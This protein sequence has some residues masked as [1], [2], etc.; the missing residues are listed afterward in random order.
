MEIFQIGD[1]VSV[2]LFNQLSDYYTK[3]GICCITHK[4][5]SFGSDV[6]TYNLIDIEN[7]KTY[8]MKNSSG[9]QKVI[10]KT[11]KFSVGD[12]VIRDGKHP[13]TITKVNPKYDVV[14]YNYITKEGTIG[15]DYSE[16]IFTKPAP[17]E[18]LESLIIYET[19]L[20]EELTRV[21][22][23]IVLLKELETL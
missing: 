15:R 2:P 17:A 21:S 18:T 3:N 11:P 16:H 4:I 6:Y 23:K 12:T 20:K 19:H 9:F 22:R 14:K 5:Q 1:I 8:M 7:N 13:V 10:L